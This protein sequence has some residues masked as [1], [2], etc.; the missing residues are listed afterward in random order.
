MF[1]KVAYFAIDSYPLFHIMLYKNS[2]KFIIQHISM[3]F[4]IQH[5]IH[6]SKYTVLVHRPFSTTVQQITKD[7][8]LRSIVRE[9]DFPPL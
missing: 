2:M 5:I 4:I 3:K 8:T 9:S 6:A 1:P 7:V